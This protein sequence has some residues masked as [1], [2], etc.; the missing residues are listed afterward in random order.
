MPSG[1]W[2][3]TLLS[4]FTCLGFGFSPSVQAIETFSCGTILDEPVCMDLAG[5]CVYS[6]V[7]LYTDYFSASSQ[8]ALI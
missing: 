1:D 5:V 8:T 4:L 2:E 3:V 7:M 6:C